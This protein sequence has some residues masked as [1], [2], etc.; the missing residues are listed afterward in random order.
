MMLTGVRQHSADAPDPQPLGAVF[1]ELQLVRVNVA[2]DD[3]PFSAY[4]NGCG[5][6]LAP[7]R[8]ADVL[9][10]IAL[11]GSGH[12]RHQMGGSILHHEPPLCKGRQAL[13]ISRT[14]HGEAVFEP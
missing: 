5:K 9:H 3:L 10:P 7:R 12:H 14:A 1:N 13:Q 11:L 4:G 2:G 8:S 6:G